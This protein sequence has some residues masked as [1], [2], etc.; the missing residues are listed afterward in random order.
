MRKEVHGCKS[1]QDKRVPLLDRRK[2]ERKMSHIDAEID[3]HLKSADIRADQ[4]IVFTIHRFSKDKK[5]KAE[6]EGRLII[7][8][9]V[10]SE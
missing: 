4:I 1:T 7:K 10:G 9:V 2:G 6:F 8:R 5:H 3:R